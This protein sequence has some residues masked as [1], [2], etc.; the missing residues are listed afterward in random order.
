MTRC[1]IFDRFWWPSL[2]QDI[3]WY[4]TTCH[5]CQLRQ[6]TK[7]CILPT[8]AVPAPLLYKLYIDTM[9]MP[10][11]GSFRYITQA[12]CSLTAWPEWHALCAE[13]GRTLGMFLFK[14][15]LCRWGAVE[16]VITDNGTPYVAALN[17]L[18]DRYGIQH[19]CISAYN[20]CANSIM[21]WQHHTII[22]SLVKACEG[23]VSKW[24][25]RAPH[26]F[27]ADHATIR[28]STGH[29]PFYMA[30]GVEPLLLFDITLTMFLVPDLTKPLDTADLIATCTHQLKMCKEDLNAIHNN[31]LKSC[32]TSVHQFEKQ[33]QNTILVYDF[34]PGNLVLLRN[35]GLDLHLGCK[36]K[37]RYIGPM[38]V[39]RRTRNGAYH[40]AE[41]NGAVSK[42]CYTA[43][44]L[45]LYFLCS[46]TSIPVTRVLAHGDL[47]AV[48]QDT[49][50]DIN[51]TEQGD[52]QA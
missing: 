41:L 11:A 44:C 12:H 34:K 17:W 23:N 32:L 21:E 1:I 3:K 16:E 7:I 51:N 46:R 18:V 10:P 5:Q 24:P 43:F 45:V 26:V 8:V 47:V 37:P 2:E 49:T 30:H 40:L 28:R 50:D 4:I 6:T 29:S 22:E 27:W 19:I 14:E 13:T 36:A 52:N 33:Y 9:L 20:L 35:S 31:V 48:V 38:V 15:V 39:I 42:L 25:T